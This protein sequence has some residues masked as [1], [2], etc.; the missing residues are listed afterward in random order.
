[1]IRLVFALFGSIVGLVG[2]SSLAVLLSP[3][4]SCVFGVEDAF[5]PIF[6]AA[7]G[8]WYGQVFAQALLERMGRES[9]KLD[10]LWHQ[11]LDMT[12]GV[13][14][15]YHFVAGSAIAIDHYTDLV[16]PL[17]AVVPIFFLG[18]IVFGWF[19]YT[20]TTRWLERREKEQVLAKPART[21][22]QLSG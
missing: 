13:W 1:V 16:V 5:G 17:V 19:F 18:L 14:I 4:P 20:S 7:F 15:G 10:G 9:F 11:L 3:Y 12:F 22:N 6:G 2:G 8:L 21:G